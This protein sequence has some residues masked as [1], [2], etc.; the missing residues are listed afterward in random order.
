MESPQRRASLEASRALTDEYLQR[1]M[2]KLLLD[3]AAGLEP[4]N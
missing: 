1:L 3:L 2:P 4:G